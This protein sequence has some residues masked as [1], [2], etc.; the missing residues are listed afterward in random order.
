MRMNS[1]DNESPL[2]CLSQSEAGKSVQ[3][4]H[5]HTGV[6]TAKKWESGVKRSGG[7]ALKLLNRGAE[8]WGE[9]IGLI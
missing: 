5:C 9:S 8:V 7:L 6:S 4:C 2:F 3:T 1:N